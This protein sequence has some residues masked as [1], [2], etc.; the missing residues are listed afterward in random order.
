[1]H[2]LV[3]TQYFWPEQFKINDIVEELQRRGHSVVVL[4]GKPNYPTGV[5]FEQYLRSPFKYNSYKGAKVIRVPIIA[6]GKNTFSLIL[7]YFSFVLSA[8]FF[9]LWFLRIYKFDTVFVFGTSP[10]TVCL[11]A[12][13]IGKVKKAKIVLWVLDL[14]PDTLQA[15]GVVRSRF[16]LWLLAGL[17]KFIYQRSD[18][19]LGQS[20]E[21]VKRIK[22]YK[23]DVKKVKFF[24]N[25]AEDIFDNLSVDK[26]PELLA[27]A[28]KFNILFAGNLGEAQGLPEIIETIKILKKAD[29]V[30][31][32]F[33]GNGRKFEWMQEEITRNE[34]EEDCI[35][36][37][38]YPLDRMPSFY[39]HADALL[40]SL[41]E[42]P[43]FSLTIPGKVQSYM[44][45]GKPVLG[46]ISGEGS[47]VIL[48]AHAG[49][50]CAAGD[51]QKLAENIIFMASLSQ[52]E[53]D[54]FG[55]NG[56]RYANKEFN[57]DTLLT[58]LEGWLE[59]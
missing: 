56:L 32:I 50:V 17:V 37:G 3:V 44:K 19:V 46:M 7:N 28:G 47:R 15:I 48:D 38:S 23:T 40:V 39:A 18:L 11:P 10:I 57:R 58:K 20:R 51:Y 8:S 6:R 41:A 9:G 31:W 55:T 16:A 25:W 22:A 59:K 2:I 29:M 35:L 53:L 24:P 5:V 34:L 26:A 13:F 43:A 45:F 49:L 27:R 21:F 36:M 52:K 1:M 54:T 14:W 30:R 42:A 33:V 12:I 4:T